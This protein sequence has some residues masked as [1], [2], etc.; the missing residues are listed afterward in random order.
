MI[1]ILFDKIF[2]K[3][4]SCCLQ[5]ESFELDKYTT[6]YCQNTLGIALFITGIVTVSGRQWQA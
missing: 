5:S 3:A 6:N 4:S 1:Q 2:S